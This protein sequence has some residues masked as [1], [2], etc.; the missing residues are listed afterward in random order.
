MYRELAVRVCVCVRASISPPPG[1]G[2]HNNDRNSSR[3]EAAA[4][5]DAQQQ[6]QTITTMPP[7]LLLQR[8]NSVIMS[9]SDGWLAFLHSWC[10]CPKTQTAGFLLPT[11]Q[12]SRQTHGLSFFFFFLRPP[13]FILYFCLLFGRWAKEDQLN[14]TE[15]QCSETGQ[16]WNSRGLCLFVWSSSF[17]PLSKNIEW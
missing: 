8:W 4:A 10:F 14:N 2:P 12:T 9:G 13:R 16:S 15:K 1:G 7:Q 6:Q 5:W 17:L 3:R 11:S